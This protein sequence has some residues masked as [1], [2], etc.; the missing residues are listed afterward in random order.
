MA[1]GELPFNFYHADRVNF[2]FPGIRKLVHNMSSACPILPDHSQ[3]NRKLFYDVQFIDYPPQLQNGL[4]FF[5]TNK[6]NFFFHFT[7]FTLWVT[8]T[9]IL[10][11]T[12]L[13]TRNGNRPLKHMIC[14]NS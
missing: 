1:S 14:H 10:K 5:S 11:I 2:K 7:K 6:T 3:K 4:I 13:L 9:L 12:N 8:L